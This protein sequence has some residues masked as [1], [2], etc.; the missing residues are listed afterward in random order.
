MTHII[1]LIKIGLSL[2]ISSTKISLKWEIIAI[3]K[4]KQE[5]KIP[6]CFM[7][8]MIQEDK[9]ESKEGSKNTKMF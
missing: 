6:G 8:K 4:F 1:G 2:L 5:N 9:S 7:I 3:Q